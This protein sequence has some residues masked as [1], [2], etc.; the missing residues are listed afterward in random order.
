MSNALDG[1]HAASSRLHGH[2]GDPYRSARSKAP[3]LPT[4]FEPV[5]LG[6]A[7]ALG[8]DAPLDMFPDALAAHVEA[9]MVRSDALKRVSTQPR[10]MGEYARMRF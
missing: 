7:E 1:L 4:H 8:V 2:G 10:K 3:A 5:R 6:V 9:F